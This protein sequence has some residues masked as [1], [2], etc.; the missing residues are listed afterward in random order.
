MFLSCSSIVSLSARVRSRSLSE[1]GHQAVAHV[2]A[3]A[4]D[5]LDAVRDQQLLGHGLRDVALVGE[6]LAEA[7]ADPCEQGGD[8]LAIVAS[9][10]REAHGEQRAALVDDPVPLAAV[11]PADGCLA[12]GGV[13]G[14][15]AVR[16]DAR[17][18]ADGQRGGVEEA[19]AR[20]LTHRRV[21]LGHQRQQH[22][23]Q[24]LDEARV[25]HQLGNL[26]AQMPLDILGGVG[27]ERAARAQSGTG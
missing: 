9:A 20:A 25:A 1:R 2:L 4:G 21:Q 6:E 14:A 22:A 7:G 16:L 13:D 8:G 27:L 10:A 15:D 19:D 3:P 11:E 17:V 5:E 24:E 12:T 18:V 23:R 26:G